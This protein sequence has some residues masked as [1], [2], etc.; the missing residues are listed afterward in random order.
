[1]AKIMEIIA[2]ETKGK[3]YHTYKYSYDSVGV[4][5]VDYDD[6]PDKIMKWQ[7]SGETD[8]P[9]HAINLK[10]EADRLL[11]V[12]AEPL[13]KY[14]LDGSRHVFKVD[15]I[16]Y[17]KQVYPVVA[18]QIGVGCCKRENKRMSKELFYR[19]LVVAL[20][21]KANP[22]VWNDNAYFPAKLQKV[23]DS[24]ELRRL[25]LRF[26]AILPYKTSNAMSQG[27]KL[28]KLAIAE[29][30]DYMVEAEKRMVH[31]LVKERKLN[32]DSYLLKDGS[33]QYQNTPLYGSVYRCPT[34]S[35]EPPDEAGLPAHLPQ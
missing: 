33:L 1:M 10:P 31:Q 26:S 13:I 35:A 29:I 9:K 3:S 27:V 4:P 25:G 11:E 15:D 14:F 32:Q 19:E 5:S 8:R 6:D 20:P 34:E 2:K 30:Q 22:D 21:D 24:P 16:A 7:E 12:G 23:N 17:N 18:G 28:D